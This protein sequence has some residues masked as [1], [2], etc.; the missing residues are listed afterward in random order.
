MK[1][2]IG[3]A[4]VVLFFGGCTVKKVFEFKNSPTGQ[5]I[6]QLQERKQLIEQVTKS[7]TL[8]LP[9]SK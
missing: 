4:I 6:E 8:T 1:V 3:I 7:P 9:V 5:V 2:K